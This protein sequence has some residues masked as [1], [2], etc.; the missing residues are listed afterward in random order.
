V[1]TWGWIDTVHPD[2][3]GGELLREG[4]RQPDHAVLRRTVVGESG[5]ALQPGDRA[6]QHD[7]TSAA[8]SQVRNRDLACAPRPAEVHVEH[9][10]PLLLGELLRGRAVHDPGVRA[11]EVQAAQCFNACVD[12]AAQS[13]ELADVPLRRPYPAVERLHLSRGLGQVVAAGE[14]VP[15]GL[16]R[17]A[18]VKSDD[19]G[20]LRGEAHRVAAALAAGGPGDK[21][22]LAGG[23]GALGCEGREFNA[24]LAS[25]PASIGSA[26]PVT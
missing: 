24:H 2:P 10:R 7:R 25:T 23:P 5:Y 11:D 8:G 9:H 22:D 18:D 13:I 1:P 15:H 19:V 26:T 3:L 16:H 20:T 14:G 12:G 4:P 6:G 21:R 17:R